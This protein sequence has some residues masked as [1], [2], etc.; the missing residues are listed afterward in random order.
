MTRKEVCEKY[1]VITHAKLNDPDKEADAEFEK[2]IAQL[3][4]IINNLFTY[5]K[6]GDSK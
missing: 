2:Y 4:K 6:E 5:R 3:S 1:G